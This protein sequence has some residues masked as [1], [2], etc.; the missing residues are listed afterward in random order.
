M[1]NIE[2]EVSKATLRNWERS[3]TNVANK[4][5][6]RANKR[7]SK[8]QIKPLE[9]FQNNQILDL[10]NKYKNDWYS[11]IE[12]L[13]SFVLNLT[14]NLKN[15]FLQEELNSWKVIKDRIIS[16]IINFPIDENIEEDI[17]WWI[18][19]YLL[20]EW[21][22]NKKGSYYTP[23]N[24]IQSQIK[25]YFIDWQKV[26]DL[27][28]WSWNY[29]IN[30]PSTNPL[31]IYG[32]D[33]DPIAVKLARINLMLK[34]KNI[35]FSPN[36]FCFDTLTTKHFEEN[37][38]DLIISNPPYWA[39]IESDYKS[40]IVKSWES[41]SFF[42][43]KWISLL[44]NNWILSYILPES[45][46]NVWKHKD[47]RKFLLNYSILDIQEL[48][49][50]FNG[51]FSPIIRIDIQKKPYSW[52]SET[53]KIKQE[54]FLQNKNYVFLM[55]Q[56]NEIDSI[57]DKLY[58]HTSLFLD[59]KNSNWAL[60][61]MTWNNKE[62]LVERQEDWTVPIYSGKE[63]KPFSLAKTE[64]FLKFQPSLFQQIAT[65]EIYKTKPK[66][67]YKFISN[68]LVFALDNEWVFSLNSAN[69]VIPKID[70]PIKVI[71]ALFNSELYQIVFQNKF[72][73][74]KVLKQ[75]IQ[76]LP[77]PILENKHIKEIEK[78]VDK[79]LQDWNLEEKEKLDNYIFNILIS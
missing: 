62:F 51:V 19:Q 56:N 37:F 12:I 23:K 24:I 33:K 67:I 60:W 52:F 54:E 64:K 44:K 29:L 55:N 35:D 72:K 11:N 78:M 6:N 61:I 70:Y 74:I 30:I 65:I 3:W 22:K 47:I 26:L 7:L 31:H 14:K 68:K 25:D 27:C 53:S 28:C 58:S 8:K 9:Y 32:A 1:N 43:E 39:K 79:I 2:N 71:L 38:F 59:N 4:L 41:F 77:L 15:S 20:L 50:I 40:D 42:I 18:Y 66:L 36:I 21:E 16:E 34:Y 10:S 57:I 69:I 13:Y 63:V 5:E 49:R 75:H 48:G 76:Q 17:L 73:S 45:L 46:L